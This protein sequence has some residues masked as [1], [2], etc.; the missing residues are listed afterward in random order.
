MNKLQKRQ[1]KTLVMQ[2]K[3]AHHQVKKCIRQGNIRS[4]MGL[5]VD[6][7]G[8]GMAIGELVESTEGEGHPSVAILE[9]YCELVYQIHEKLAGSK[10]TNAEKIY[11]Q[12][13]EKLIE[14]E[15]SI[16]KIAVRKEVV[17]LPYKASM[18][19]SLESVWRAANE[20]DNYDA[21]VIPIPYYDKN[22]DGSFREMHY[23]G[24]QY[25]DYVPITHYEEYDFEGRRPDM[26]YIH[27]SYDN[28]N[29][30]TGVHPFFF[31]EN[32]KKFTKKLVYI[33]YFVLGEINPNDDNA[34]NSIKHFILQLGVFNAD[35]VIVQSED[36]RQAY[37]KA[38]MD[39][40]NAHGENVRKYWEKKILG[41]GSPKFDKV[42]NTGREDIA[43]PE[44]W[45]KIIRKPDGSRKKIIFYNTGLGA[46]LANNEKM[47]AKIQGALRVFE[48][49]KEEVALLW[50]P[51]PLVK[52]TLESMLPQL[53]IEY[54]RI[55][56]NYIEEGWGIYDDTSDFDRAI[57]LSDAYY[58]DMSSVVHLCQKAGKPVMI[59]NCDMIE[60]W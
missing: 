21:Y 36:M 13:K 4:A 12:L 56:R 39:F 8:G 53:C 27:N 10:D 52:A 19:D 37:I 17:F 46:L 51:H 22:P 45:M 47:L 24:S 16:N 54:D 48:A 30:V 32:L 18:W 33:P 44:Q 25:P 49:N 29:L 1:V 40:E 20:D 6:C 59:Q 43:I 2:M 55:V 5:L 38:L 57:A 60:T 41:L 35:R 34:V 58:G 7:Q 28:N 3:E 31:S 9:E 26:I 15:K 23:E 50:R 11:T 14:T 42:V